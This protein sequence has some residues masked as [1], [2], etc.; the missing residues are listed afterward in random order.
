MPT[1]R[2]WLVLSGSAAILVVARMLGL[3][4]LFIMSAVGL[5]LVLFAVVRVRMSRPQ[6]LAERS[7]MPDRLHIGATARIELSLTNVSRR[8]SPVVEGRDGAAEGPGGGLVIPSLE[9]GEQ[10]GVTYRLN[11]SQRGSHPIGPLAIELQDPFGLAS[12]KA[13]VSKADRLIVFPQVEHVT[14]LP[15]AL[16][17]D[18]ES[19]SDAPT[20]LGRR[21]DEYST[22]RPYE[23]GDDLR[24]VH[25][26]STARLGEL[27]IRQEEIPWDGRTTV[28]VDLRRQAHTTESLEKAVSA[29][30]SVFLAGI[31]RRSSIRLLTTE[32]VDTGFG[33]ANAH[34][35]L[36][37]EQLAQAR[38]T[39]SGSLLAALSRSS[40]RGG[41]GAL[42]V[43]TTT[44][45]PAVDLQRVAALS[46]NFPIIVAVLVQRSTRDQPSKA[47]PSGGVS[48]VTVPLRQPFAVAWGS[49]A[50][51]RATKALR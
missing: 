33:S 26:P 10:A 46:R 13:V 20:Y 47:M 35:Q 12:R 9:P 49:T 32:G 21:G 30:A 31:R 16:G 8:P 38:W 29:T 40:Q 19:G 24:R 1:H 42:I 2:G 28:L 18:P 39:S 17:G 36:G 43:V 4:E 14:S 37:L 44:A 15:Q 7:V 45:V 48:V 34:G 41:A 22:L 51:L 27:T 3:P 50:S 5:F 23:D 11:A 25:W 6:F